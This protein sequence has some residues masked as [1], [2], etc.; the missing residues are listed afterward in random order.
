VITAWTGDIVEDAGDHIVIRARWATTNTPLFLGYT[1]FEPGD[2]F[3][4]RYYAGRWFSVWQVI[5]QRTGRTKGWYANVCQPVEREGDQLRFVDM[6]LDVFVWPDGRFVI[7][8]EEDLERAQLPQAETE[9]AKAGL[10]EVSTWIL[11]RR[12]P[13]DC[14]GPPRRVE[15]FWDEEPRHQG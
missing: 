13:F 14:I 7:L 8:D 1:V 9:A 4:E 2:V 11:E 12:P 3:L 10:A 5:S 15:P 6:E